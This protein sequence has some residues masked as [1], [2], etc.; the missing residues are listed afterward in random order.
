MDRTEEDEQHLGAL[1]KLAGRGLRWGL[2]GNL[3]IKAGSFALSLILARTLLPA[4]FGIYAIALAATQF[5]M[6]IKDLG[7]MA[8]T[9]QWRGRFE[10][11]V[12][13][14]TVLSFVS[15]TALYGVFWLAAPAYAEMSGAPHATPVIRL[16]TAII[17]VEGFTAVRSATLIRR[18]EQ[19][20]L[21]LAIGAGFAVNAVLAVL[22]AVNG[23]GPYSF[24]VGQVAQAAV[25]GVI[26]LVA[27]RLPVR[28]G[29][30]RGVAARLL[31]FG[32]PSAA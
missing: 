1:G 30:D 28:L 7:I 3:V 15:A 25:T 17:L 5:V 10:D 18:F 4:D 9:M 11:M 19:H 8:A 27:A 29:L 23:A 14:A 32:V 13:T 6:S 20:R 2:L 24:A 21:T 12:P 16:L 26:T 22:L 31:R